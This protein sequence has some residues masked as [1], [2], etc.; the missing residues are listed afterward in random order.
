V[1][2]TAV[3]RNV[4][5]R[6]RTAL[7]PAVAAPLYAA[8]RDLDAERRGRSEANGPARA[9]IDDTRRARAVHTI[10]ACLIEH[11]RA[12]DP[13]FSPRLPLDVLADLALVV[14]LTDLG[15]PSGPPLHL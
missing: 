9:T 13:S 6:L 12:P 3:V 11:L 10:R 4:F 8:L 5:G 7:D 15:V 1:D 14:Q 2:V